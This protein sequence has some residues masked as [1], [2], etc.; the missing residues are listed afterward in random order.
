MPC[1]GW[2]VIISLLYSTVII[3]IGAGSGTGIVVLILLLV[4]VIILVGY[5]VLKRNRQKSEENYYYS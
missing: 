5:I 3:Y 2:V 4:I 1:D